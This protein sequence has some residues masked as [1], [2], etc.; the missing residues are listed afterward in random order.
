LKILTVD[1]HALV[2]EGLRQ[3][4]KGIDESVVVLDA[5]TCAKA[6]EIAASEPDLDLVL[7]ELPPAR[8]ER[9]VREKIFLR[10]KDRFFSQGKV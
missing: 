5:G 4:L 2:R 3:V 1:G 6:F 8:H 10:D 7:L 9:H